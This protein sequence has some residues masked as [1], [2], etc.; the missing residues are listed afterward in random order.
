MPAPA[1]APRSQFTWCPKEER[2]IPLLRCLTCRPPC[3]A[4]AAAVAEPNAALWVA[5]G[6]IKEAYT[7]KP[8]VRAQET[9][10]ESPARFF[11]VEDG[12]L[13]DLNPDEYSPATVYE[14]LGS[15]GVERRFVKP[16]E[17]GDLVFEG[18]KPPKQTVP[19]LVLKNGTAA[20]LS[21]W[22][23]LISNPERLSEAK[24]VRVARAVKQVFVLKAL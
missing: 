11:L 14:A 8:K 20:V 5:A 23:E 13:R 2:F 1:D 7:M 6:K 22:D 4:S 18:K 19:V 17:K 24:E 3:A 10:E 21:S 9:R 16:E 12:T 15:Y